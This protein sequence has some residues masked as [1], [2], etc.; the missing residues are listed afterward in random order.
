MMDEHITFENGVRITVPRPTSPKDTG[1]GPVKPV[2]VDPR[3]YME[4]YV[5]GRD[6][7]PPI[8]MS[9]PDGSFMVEISN[10]IN[11]QD[12]WH[13]SMTHGELQFCHIG[14]RTVETENG[15]VS[16][17]PGQFIWFPKGLSH[18]NIGYPPEV[19][20]LIMYISQDLIIHETPA[21]IK[22][23]QANGAVKETVPA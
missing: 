6:G 19:L 10:R 18:R 2:V 5:V 15:T 12:K 7:S 16:Q 4:G 11:E 8:I 1:S 14:R 9:T 3:D 21:Q 23:K 22:A 17:G 13:R 20:A